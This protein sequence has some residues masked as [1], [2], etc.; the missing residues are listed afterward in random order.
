MNSLPGKPSPGPER[1]SALSGQWQEPEARPERRRAGRERPRASPCRPGWPQE[2]RAGSARALPG[3]P[4]APVASVP[5]PRALSGARSRRSPCGAA[6][7]R[8]RRRQGRGCGAACPG[9]RAGRAVP[10]QRDPAGQLRVGSWAPPSRHGGCPWAAAAP[11]RT[12]PE[13]PGRERGRVPSPA[14]LSRDSSPSA[15]SRRGAKHRDA[16]E[17]PQLCPCVK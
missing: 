15:C 11:S 4:Q 8:P 6:C 14:C 3:A 16:Y 10:V 2:S 7:A 12:G 5:S 9:L 13:G 17:S 1:P